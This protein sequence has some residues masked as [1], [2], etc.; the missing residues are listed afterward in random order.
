[1]TAAATEEV[2]Q[3]IGRRHDADV[4]EELDFLPFTKN[5]L[6]GIGDQGDYRAGVRR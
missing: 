5:A 4:R 6:L 1:M 3:L 2:Q